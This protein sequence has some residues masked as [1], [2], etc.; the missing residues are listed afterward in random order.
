M[1]LSPA[2]PGPDWLTAL[3]TNPDARI[4]LARPAATLIWE[5][6]PPVVVGGAHPTASRRVTGE[7]RIPGPGR[8]DQLWI[9]RHLRRRPGDW[10]V[11]YT[12]DQTTARNL[13]Q[14]VTRGHAGFTYSGQ[15]EAASR[16]GPAGRTSVYARNIGT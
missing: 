15:F 9:A 8:D 14:N 4:H 13:Q 5:T 16:L 1:T 12:G 6:P 2:I 11:I 3:A 10:A 7:Q